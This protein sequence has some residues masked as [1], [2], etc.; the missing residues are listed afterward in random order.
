[1]S[2]H[3]YVIRTMIL[4]LN[5]LIKSEDSNQVLY[6]EANELMPRKDVWKN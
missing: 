5:I 6:H 1:M 3:N 2:F 4:G